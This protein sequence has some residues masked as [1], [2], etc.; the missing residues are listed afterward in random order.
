MGVYRIKN[1][2]FFF[3]A[4]YNDHPTIKMAILNYTE[5]IKLLN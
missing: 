2:N 1:I 3:A 4:I 5:P